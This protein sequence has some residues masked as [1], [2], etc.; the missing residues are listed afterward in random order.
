MIS[1]GRRRILF[2]TGDALLV[3]GALWLLR[4]LFF[5]GLAVTKSVMAFAIFP[6]VFYITGFYEHRDLLPDG[7]YLAQAATAAAI[8]FG[9]M[10]IMSYALPALAL[11]RR[12]VLMVIPGVL[13]SLPMW[14]LLSGYIIGRVRQPTRLIVHGKGPAAEA[15]VQAV[16]GHGDYLLDDPIEGSN[17]PAVVADASNGNPDRET[18]EALVGLM[19]QGHRVIDMVT[20]YEQ[21]TGRLPTEH[22]THQW[23]LAELQ[24]VRGPAYPRMRRVADLVGALLGLII[25]AIPVALF[26]FLQWLEDGGPVFFRQ[27]RVGL[28]EREFNIIKLRTMR[29]GADQEGPLWTVDRDPRIT[30]V[31]RVVRLLRLDEVPQLLNVLRGDMCLVGPRPEAVGLVRQYEDE[32]PHYHLR[33]LVPPGVTG[34]AQVCFEN[35]SSVEAVRKKLEYDLYY[36]RHMGPVFD[37]RIILR[38]I[39]VMLSGRGSR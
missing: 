10:A 7:F 2:I 1:D 13:L 34:W 32:I 4:D 15:L 6:P 23:L 8:I 25:L 31:G 30:H 26:A 33:H 38:T 18:A 36:I 24:P 20:L 21:A 12:F 27:G 19:K 16:S 39:G 5:P 9:A 11:P 28:G 37:L 17:G 14:R 35:T 29:V 3:L 22:L